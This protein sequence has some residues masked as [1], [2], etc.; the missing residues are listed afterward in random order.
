MMGKN[1]HVPT[2]NTK[3]HEGGVSKGISNL[4]MNVQMMI[5]ILKVRENI[6]KKIENQIIFDLMN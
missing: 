1:F 5:L 2:A 6:L 3:Q 4:Y